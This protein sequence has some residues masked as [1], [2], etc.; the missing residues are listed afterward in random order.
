MNVQHG[1]L[2]LSCP[3]SYTVKKS[4]L[5]RLENRTLA[6]KGLT[7]REIEEWFF[8]MNAAIKTLNPAHQ[9]A[10]SAPPLP[11]R[12]A[13]QLTTAKR[14]EAEMGFVFVISIPFMQT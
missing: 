5:V 6:L 1:V 13:K 2:F 4:G 10:V 7:V 14:Y 3:V 8:A 12:K 11:S 9:I